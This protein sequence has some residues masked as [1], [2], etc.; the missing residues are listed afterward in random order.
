MRYIKTLL[1][2][3]VFIGF[4]TSCEK[5]LDLAPN[6]KISEVTYFKNANEFKMYCNRFYVYLPSFGTV[7]SEDNADLTCG[8]GGNAISRGT[9]QISDFSGTWNNNYDL[10]RN[11]SIVLERL[12][13]V[14][15]VLKEEAKSSLGEA[16]FFRAFAYYNLLQS[17][18]GVP[19]I[20]K[21]L[22]SES[23]ELLLRRSDRV[24]I[25]KQIMADLDLAIENLSSNSE[26]A[27]S[28]KGRVCKGAALAYK[29][30]VALFEGTWQKFHSGSDANDFLGKAIDAAKKV[31]DSEE[32]QLFD[33]LGNDS[34]KHLF[35]LDKVTTNA[36][37]FTKNDNKEYILSN[38]YDIDERSHRS[39]IT[40][41]GGRLPT[42]KFADMFL[43]TDGLTI[44]ESPLFMGRETFVSEY[45][46]RDPRMTS[47]WLIP[48]GRYWHHAQAAWYRN[49]DAPFDPATGFINTVEWGTRTVTG[50]I[51]AKTQSEI[52]P[53]LGTNWPV[54]RYAEVLLNYAEALYEKNGEVSNDE[55]DASI[56][57]LKTRA[58]IAVITNAFIDAHSMSLREE[59]RRERAVEL[60]YE[61]FR[62]NDIRRWKTAEVELVKPLNGV[63]YVGTEFETH[64]WTK[65]QTNFDLEGNISVEKVDVRKFDAKKHYLLPLPRRELQLNKNLVQNPGW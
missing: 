27:P 20:T 50:Y 8:S 57:L 39:A 49:W 36:G 34:Y 64:E 55:L 31:I 9:N 44:D 46:N 62:Y 59:I 54:I 16:A 2:I 24:D 52:A 11:T 6:D 19:L 65:G 3:T 43:C 61:G 28:D 32:Y 45:E 29:S 33:K 4:L 60:C 30:R 37:G 63:E 22:T 58:G 17:Y 35:L 51:S 47:T 7:G 26:L 38:T 40:S 53:P 48:G 18:G 42:R 25:A 14:D 23:E 13:T 15:D 56:N 21:V 41:V 10:I 5:D 12:N 1:L